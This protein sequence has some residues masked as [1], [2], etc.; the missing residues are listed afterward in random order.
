MR[1]H[2]ALGALLLVCWLI[3]SAR[4]SDYYCDQATTPPQPAPGTITVGPPTPTLGHILPVI[5]SWPS[6]PPPID[7]SEKI[8]LRITSFSSSRPW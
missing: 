5:V 8:V 4:A 2:V 1:G 6:Y 7:G 3:P